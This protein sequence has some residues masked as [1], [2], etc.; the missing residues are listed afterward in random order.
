MT[1]L[2]L[3]HYGIKGQ[4]HGRR[5]FQNYDG[6]LTPEGER[7]YGIVGN[8]VKAASEKLSSKRP[9]K[10]NGPVHY[11]TSLPNGPGYYHSPTGMGAAQA[12]LYN[13]ANSAVNTAKPHSQ[14]NARKKKNTGSHHSASNQYRPG[15]HPEHPTPTYENGEPIPYSNYQETAPLTVVEQALRKTYEVVDDFLWTTAVALDSLPLAYLDQ[16]IHQMS[17]HSPWILNRRK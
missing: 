11:N 2:Y 6:T 9:H 16:Y 17:N 12:H 3:C 1:L 5:R 4:K 10:T 14:V 7:R 8:A 13:A 15:Q